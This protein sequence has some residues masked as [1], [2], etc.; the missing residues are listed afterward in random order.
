MIITIMLQMTLLHFVIKS[1][2]RG[3]QRGA[4]WRDTSGGL[5]LTFVWFWFW[6]GTTVKCLCAFF[7]YCLFIEFFCIYII[8][9]PLLK[10]LLYFSSSSIFLF[11]FS[12]TF[13]N[14]GHP[15][16]QTPNESKSCVA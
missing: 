12:K 15:S 10:Y 6:F 4:E 13:L 7:K 9:F 5:F 1:D 8:I 11:C 16:R 14:K 3:G 2:R